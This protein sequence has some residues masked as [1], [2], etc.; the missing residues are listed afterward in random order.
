MPYTVFNIDQQGEG[1]RI[2]AAVSPGKM[3]RCAVLRHISDCVDVV[4]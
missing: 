4:T 1:A 2:A 3:Y